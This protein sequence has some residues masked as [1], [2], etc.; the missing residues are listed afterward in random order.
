MKAIR[1]KTEYLFDPL[2]IDIQHPRL[3]WNCEG[4]KKQTAYRIVSENWD[5]GKVV[6]DAMHAEYLPELKDRERVN[7]KITL[8]DENDEAGEENSAFF[9]MG[10]SS[11]EA[12]WIRLRNLCAGH[13]GLTQCRSASSS[14]R[15]A[16]DPQD[17]QVAGKRYGSLFGAWRTTRT[18]SGMI[19]PALRIATVS[20]MPS[21]FSSIKF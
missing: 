17:G 13:A 5:S 12:K 2:G 4:G 8:W 10:I 6:S 1:L 16:V 15:M 7:W 9:E 3:M 14:S 11:F 21:P 19:S 20:P 18:T